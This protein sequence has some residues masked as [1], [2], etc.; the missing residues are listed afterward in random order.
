M[1]AGINPAI[2]QSSD[3]G[4]SAD[5]IE[6]LRVRDAILSAREAIKDSG[7]RRL[8]TAK[9]AV[10]LANASSDNVSSS[11]SLSP[12]SSEL[13]SSSS[14]DDTDDYDNNAADDSGGRGYD[15]NHDHNHSHAHLDNED[16]VQ[17]IV[18]CAKP[19][20]PDCTIE[21]E[22]TL[23]QRIGSGS[24]STVYCGLNLTDGS[25]V[26]VK[27]LHRFES[28]EHELIGREIK[29]LS[30]LSH[31]NI[32]RYHGI[33]TS[34]QNLYIFMEWVA[35]GS[36]AQQ[37]EQFG[38]LPERLVAK[39]TA[40]V[41]AGL[42]FL[43]ESGVAH[44]DIKAQNLLVTSNGAIKLAD[45]GAAR[46][47]TS[48]QQQK[49]G[50]DHTSGGVFGTPAFIA[51]EAIRHA[52]DFDDKADIWSLGCTVVQMVTGALPWASKQFETVFELLQ[53]VAGS[54]EA[55]PCPSA[56]TT[57][58]AFLHAC[59]QPEPKDRPKAMELRRYA[60]I[61]QALDMRRG[62]AKVSPRGPAP[63]FFPR[64]HGGQE[65]TTKPGTAT[66]VKVGG[67]TESSAKRSSKS[68]STFLGGSFGRAKLKL[69]QR[70]GKSSG[71]IADGSIAQQIVPANAA[72]QTGMMGAWKVP[73]HAYMDKGTFERRSK[74]LRKSSRKRSNAENTEDASSS[75]SSSSSSSTGTCHIS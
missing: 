30:Q 31:P 22:W 4:A 9:Q 32:V 39:H 12:S 48:R 26:A 68:G 61:V 54:G 25:L 7:R 59:F 33:D 52:I 24:K 21:F 44:M 70:F 71:E 3:A 50:N 73:E 38:A 35:G 51:P 11:S 46:N 6:R 62:T 58:L 56:S 1:S 29:I 40:Q 60:F 72:A 45:F 67:N 16:N 66:A 63:S 49:I 14:E 43:H 42:A 41:L 17:P 13:S 34:G 75:S 5:Q 53:H 47:F 27:E 19:K 15:E 74:Y 36:V 18:E 2:V 28:N 69:A 23:G 20:V 10:Q 37:L 8:L 55:P 65:P 64:K 57:L